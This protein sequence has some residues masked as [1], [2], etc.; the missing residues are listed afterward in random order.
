M[1]GDTSQHKSG[2]GAVGAEVRQARERP[3]EG[4]GLAEANPHLV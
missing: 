4:W 3:G 1:S 2:K